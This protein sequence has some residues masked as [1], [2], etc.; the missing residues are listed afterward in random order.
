MLTVIM[1][2][3]VLL[4]IAGVAAAK[5]GNKQENTGKKSTILAKVPVTKNEQPMYFRLCEAFPDYVILAQVAFS[6][7]LKTSDRAARNSFDRKVADFMICTKAFEVIAFVELDDSSHHG[8]EIA[9]AKRDSLLTGAGYKVFRYKRVP[10]VETLI[11]H[12]TPSLGV[13]K[14]VNESG[15]NKDSPFKA[16]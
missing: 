9:D 16:I 3:I 10:N 4:I 5:L 14:K 2:V 8:Q 12:I 1:I 6:S 15:A 11:D 7:V 13:S